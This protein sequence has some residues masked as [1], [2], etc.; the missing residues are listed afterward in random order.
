MSHESQN[1]GFNM[2]DFVSS[3]SRRRLETMERLKANKGFMLARF[4]ELGATR[5]VISYAGSG[6]SGCVESVDVY[7]GE[8]KIEPAGVLRVVTSHSVYDP[9]LPG[10]R[11]TQEVKALP[12]GEALEQFVYDW[13][14]AEHGGWE[15]NDGA[16]GECTIDVSQGSFLLEHRSYYTECDYSEH[17]L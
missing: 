13:L 9:A 11:E 17:E 2:D 12:L 6:D 8:E 14:E 15:N 16:S 1:S 3:L 7:R 10:W 5:V 4:L